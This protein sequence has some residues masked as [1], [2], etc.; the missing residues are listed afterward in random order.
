MAHVSGNHNNRRGKCT[1]HYVGVVAV[2]AI[3]FG[4]K[5]TVVHGSPS[6][7]RYHLTQATPR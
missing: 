6:L 5:G 2:T 3:Q 1:R 7:R 4:C